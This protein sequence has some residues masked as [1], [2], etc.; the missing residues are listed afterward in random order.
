MERV[1]GPAAR[2]LGL[3]MRVA[4]RKPLALLNKQLAR[5]NPPQGKAPCHGCDLCCRKEDLM[6]HPESGD[7]PATFDC[8]PAV[9]PFTGEASYKLRKGPNGHCIYLAP[10]QGCT[11]HERAP[12]VCRKFDCRAL[13]L[14]MGGADARRAVDQGLVS[15]AVID[16]GKELLRRAT[17]LR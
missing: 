9:N 17:F 14:A 1:A 11:I 16:R 12:S 15:K 13:V 2:G 8:E 6:L 7:D 4:T 3:G 10:G 5:L